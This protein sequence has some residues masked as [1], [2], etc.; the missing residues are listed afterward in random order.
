[1][2]FVAGFENKLADCG[3]PGWGGERQDKG[4]VNPNMSD[5]ALFG[6]VLVQ[7]WHL[8]TQPHSGNI[9]CTVIVL[10]VKFCGCRN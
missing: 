10:G 6:P 9:Y 5:V 8:A 7:D 1:M 4:T 3:L 2:N